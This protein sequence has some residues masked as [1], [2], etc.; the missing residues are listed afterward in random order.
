MAR[1]PAKNRI[2]KL[3][4][5]AELYFIDGLTQAKIAQKVGVTRSMVSRMLTEARDEGIV[6]IKIERKFKYADD[7][8][9]KLTKA[10]NLNEAVIYN[11]QPENYERNLSHLGTAV[12]LSQDPQLVLSREPPPLRFFLHLDRGGRKLFLGRFHA[13]HLRLASFALYCN[14]SGGSCL[15]HVGTEGNEGTGKET[16][17]GGR[18]DSKVGGVGQ[19]RGALLAGMAAKCDRR[20]FLLGRS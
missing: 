12:R 8:Q 18:G 7:L 1:K 6:S 4:D 15:T 3:A 17:A 9:E 10:F 2:N 11:G 13:F 19:L 16:A 14:K 20:R 5:V